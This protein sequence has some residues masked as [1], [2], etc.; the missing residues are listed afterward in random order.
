MVSSGPKSR[1]QHHVDADA[2]LKFLGPR[3]LDSLSVWSGHTIY[4]FLVR[5]RLLFL[6]ARIESL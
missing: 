2:Q 4:Q 6:A 5:V 3:L 1:P